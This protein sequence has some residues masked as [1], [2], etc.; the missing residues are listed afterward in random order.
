MLASVTSKSA[1]RGDARESFGRRPQENVAGVEARLA[2]GGIGAEIEV[3]KVGQKALVSGVLEGESHGEPA[4]TAKGSQHALCF[5]DKLAVAVGTHLSTSV[6]QLAA[7]GWH[8][9]IR[10]EER[11]VGKE[12]RSRW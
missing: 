8:S 9:A 7:F 10:S 2:V 11:R 1:S 4:G 6:E 12:C 5:Q 3:G